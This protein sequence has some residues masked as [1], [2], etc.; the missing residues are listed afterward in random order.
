[1]SNYQI[2]VIT[3]GIE[4][5]ELQFAK[6]RKVKWVLNDWGDLSFECDVIPDSLFELNLIDNSSEI[7]LYKNNMCV[8]SGAV[9]AIDDNSSTLKKS[10][11]ITAKEI[12]YFLKD[13]Y[14]T[15]TYTNQEESSIAWDLINQTQ[16]NTLGLYNLNHTS[17]GITQG[18]LENWQMRDRT[19]L[20]DE[21]AKSLKQI[22]EVIVGGDFE[23]TPTLTKSSLKVFSHYQQKGVQKDVKFDV[24][25]GSISDVKRTIDNRNIANYIIGI[26][27][28][29]TSLATDSN[30][31][32]IAKYKIRQLIYTNKDISVQSTLDQAVQGILEQR[33][34][35]LVSY[36][37]TINQNPQ[38]G[39]F[40]V[41]DYVRFRASLESMGGRFEVDAYQRVFEVALD[42]ADDNSEKLALKVGE[43]KP[44]KQNSIVDILKNQSNRV[45]VL[46]K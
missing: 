35:P 43:F 12:G 21:I 36:D 1:M 33:Q 31:M 18:I 8:W 34:A 10:L 15:A 38:I 32:R 20:N 45:A 28:G 16:N 30:L 22:T 13:R 3:D 41:G 19:Y 37:F 6:N 44:F 17:F 5:G 4:Q 24:D 40:D 11:K 26:G 25:D 23:I 2:K 42:I 29:I 9:L 46:E 7:R 39:S 27:N 14:A